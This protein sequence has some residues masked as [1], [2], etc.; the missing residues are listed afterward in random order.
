MRTCNGHDWRPS[1]GYRTRGV[2]APS[3]PPDP[4]RAARGRSTTSGWRGR[5]A[6]SR[7][8]GIGA[9]ASFAQARCCTCDRDAGT[10]PAACSLDGEISRRRLFRGSHL[11]LGDR[12]EPLQGRVGSA[13]DG[14]LVKAASPL[15]PPEDLPPKH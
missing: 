15:P 8:L 2:S 5:Q 12:A 7:P 1:D 6:T 13:R 14:M 11:Q 4:G 10:A 3:D 9:R